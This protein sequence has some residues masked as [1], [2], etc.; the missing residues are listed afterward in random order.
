MKAALKWVLQDENVHTA[1]PAFSNYEQLMDDLSVMEDLTLTLEEKRDLKL[2]EELGFSGLYCQQC[3][4]C[5]HQCKADLDIPTLMRSY[6]YAFG[7]QDHKK[8]KDTLRY[9]T[10][11]DIPCNNCLMC[12]VW[13]SLGFDVKSR[14]MDIGRILEVPGEFLG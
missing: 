7:Y 10:S 2:G 4:S 14:A 1:V 9:W 6:M 12:E 5:L 3:G 13:C 8:A 11:S